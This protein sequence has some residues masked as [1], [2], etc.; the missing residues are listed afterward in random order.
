MTAASKEEAE[1]NGGEKA[2]PPPRPSLPPPAALA[3]SAEL[4]CFC[5]AAHSYRMKY[6]VL[7]HNVVSR[8]FETA[9]HAGVEAREPAHGHDAGHPEPATP[10]VGHNY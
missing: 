4:L 2:A 8:V 5:A 6:Y 3:A 10:H 7:R 1:E 9:M